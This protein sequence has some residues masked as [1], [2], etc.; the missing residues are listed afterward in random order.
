MEF[1]NKNEIVKSLNGGTYKYDEE[2]ENLIDKYILE[3]SNFDS[4]SI[5]KIFKT[6]EINEILV[7]NDITL[8]T[9]QSN[10]IAVFLLT[11]GLEIDKKLRQLEKID[12]FKYIIFDTVSSFYIEEKAEK[13]QNEIK[14]ELLKNNKYMLNRFSPGYGDYPLEVN[15]K[16]LKT[17]NGNKLGIFLTEKKMFIPSKT[18][19]GIIASGDIKSYFNFCKTCNI[20]KDCTKIKEGKKCFE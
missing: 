2:V 6:R 18:I 13:L 9:E 7:G 5:F 12:K 14:I 10:E 19:S 20:A 15:E 3:I 8:Y 1:I 16:I 11:L 17:L 4:K